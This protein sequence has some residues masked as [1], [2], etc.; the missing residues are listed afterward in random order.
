[1]VQKNQTLKGFR[2]ITPEE[3]VVRQRVID[4]LR[5][6]FEFFGFQPI[7]TPSLEYA[8]VLL[9]KYGKEADKL[10]YTFEDLGGRQIGLRYDLT[11]PVARFLTSHQNEIAYPFKRY[12]IQNVFRA[13]KPQRGR[14]REFTQCDID[15]FGLSSPFADAEIILVVYTALKNLGFKQFTIQI[16]DR[17]LLKKLLENVKITNKNK[18]L[19]ILQSIDKLDKKSQQ[20][21]I[22]ELK[23]KGFEK[24][25]I[26]KIFKE[27]KRLE[28]NKTLKEIFSFLN[29]SDVNKNYYQFNPILVR[30]LD[31]YTGP[32]FEA[33]VTKPD[34]GSIAGG[35]RYDNLVKQ[36]GGPDITGTG[37]SFGLERVVEVIKNQNLWP[38]IK[39]NP[40]KVLVTIFSPELEKQSTTMAQKLRA[41][42]INTELY[43]DPEERLDKQLQYANRKNIPWVAIIGPDETKNNTITLKNMKSGNQQTL[44]IDKAIKNLSQT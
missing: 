36:I 27:L 18:Q 25:L 10:I 41:K 20:F 16:N 14:Y 28:P 29:D 34:I 22:K 42:G 23:E 32:V 39:I 7:E 13:E 12:Q 24:Q 15:T 21:V 37:L 11:V 6:T 8:E 3:A 43:L 26:N 19:T 38:E 1:M 44:L 40:T 2:D 17:K 31:Y 33:V 4:I 30:G 35:G 5:Q 9:N